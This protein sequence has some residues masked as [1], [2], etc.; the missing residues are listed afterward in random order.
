MV[1]GL[2]AETPWRDDLQSSI[3]ATLS[4][5]L[6]L[7]RLIDENTREEEITVEGG[8]LRDAKIFK[9]PRHLNDELLSTVERMVK[10]FYFMETGKVLVEHY[11]LSMF[12]PDAVHP[13]LAEEI[14]NS[15]RSARVRSVNGGTVCYTFFN[16]QRSDIVS[17][18]NLFKSVQLYFVMK[19]LGWREK[20]V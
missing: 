1:F 20:I 15:M 11:E 8:E 4:N 13:E 19:E 6:R 5:N 7:Q 14:S 2:V 18:V 12:H 3:D 16:C 10:A 17:V 9:L